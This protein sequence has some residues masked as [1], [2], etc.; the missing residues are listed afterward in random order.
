MDAANVPCDNEALQFDVAVQISCC[1]ISLH[2]LGTFHKIDC[3]HA[4]RSG[5]SSV[6][7]IHA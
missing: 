6:D 2:L 1:V 4:L 5:G 3:Q 7:Y